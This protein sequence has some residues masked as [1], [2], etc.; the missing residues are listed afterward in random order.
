MKRKKAGS[1]SPSLVTRENQKEEESGQSVKQS[2]IREKLELW[3]SMESR[4]DIKADMVEFFS[5]SPA[6]TADNKRRMIRLNI[7]AAWRKGKMG[8]IQYAFNSLLTYE[9][10]GVA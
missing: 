3:Q 6:F 2:R 10:M 1:D 5:N 7:P 9:K 8:L 4:D